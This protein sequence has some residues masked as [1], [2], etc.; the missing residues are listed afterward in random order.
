MYPY[1]IIFTISL[2]QFMKIEKSDHRHVGL[3]LSV[4][5]EIRAELLM[6]IQ[7]TVYPTP[8]TLIF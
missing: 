8:K 2:F 3:H 4:F 6:C 5:T 1:F 7:M